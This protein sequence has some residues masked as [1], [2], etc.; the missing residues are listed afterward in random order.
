MISKQTI[1][2]FVLL[3][4]FTSALEHRQWQWDRP[5]REWKA[6]HPRVN[7]K[8]AHAENVGPDPGF[9]EE[10]NPCT[11]IWWEEMPL[12][13]RLCSLGWL[14]S[15]VAFSVCLVQDVWWWWKRRGEHPTLLR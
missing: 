7:P 15:A 13:V 9:T 10:F 5:C 2:W 3:L 1:V 14:V 8:T 6:T 11:M 12:W 4:G